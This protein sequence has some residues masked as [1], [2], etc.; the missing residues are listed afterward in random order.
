VLL[1]G[2]Q[3]K[4]QVVKTLVKKVNISIDEWLFEEI[5]RLRGDKNRSEFITEKI[6]IALGF[7]KGGVQ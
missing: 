5:E 3:N 1:K 4:T 7:S 2:Y 6:A